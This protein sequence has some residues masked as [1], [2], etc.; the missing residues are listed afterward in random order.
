MTSSIS[1]VG[2]YGKD[3][4][5]MIWR[6]PVSLVAIDGEIDALYYFH[7]WEQQG[8]LSAVGLSL[9]MGLLLRALTNA[10]RVLFGGCCHRVGRVFSF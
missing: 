3:G 7:V 1:F 6:G 5:E 10:H 4:V 9:K 2:Y 8:H